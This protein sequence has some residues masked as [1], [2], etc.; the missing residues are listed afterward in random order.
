[1]LLP[2]HLNSINVPFQQVFILFPG[3]AAGNL[4]SKFFTVHLFST[5]H[6]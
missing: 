5:E 4:K 3:L 2:G 6:Q 1:M